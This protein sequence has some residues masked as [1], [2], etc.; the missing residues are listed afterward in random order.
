M[1]PECF[2]NVAA[3]LL[4][5]GSA[6]GAAALLATRFRSSQSKTNTRIEENNM[7]TSTAT[8]HQVVTR[9]EWTVARKEWLA[10]EKELT[11]ARDALSEQRRALPWVKVDK[12]YIFDTIGGRRTLAELFDGRS[13]LIIYSF[14][15]RREF[16]VS[17]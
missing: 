15:W 11:P 7:A 14:M 4:G 6:S 17:L 9:D 3:L 8:T 12:Q 1:C 13:Q 16:G 2:A 5:T 10:K